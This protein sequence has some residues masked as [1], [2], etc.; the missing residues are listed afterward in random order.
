MK[1][2]NPLVGAMGGP[3]VAA[4]GGG[5]KDTWAVS[6][7]ESPDLLYLL[8]R[9][10]FKVLECEASITRLLEKKLEYGKQMTIRIE[11]HTYSKGDFL[12][13]LCTATQAIQSTQALLGHI[14]EVEYLPV[15][16]MSTAD[17]MMGEMLDLLRQLAAAG[18]SGGGGATL[19]IV[20][21]P[22]DKYGLSGLPYGRCHAAVAYGELVVTLLSAS[23]AAGAAAA[24]Q[25]QQQA[26][27]VER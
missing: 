8:L 4:S 3:G 21:P 19:E 6:F 2:G 18:G 1:Q 14:L 17:G 7:R 20:K 26:V 13:R 11:G 9:P 10:D 15:S 24:A 12:L 16:S 22:Y 23:S 25:Q 5:L 27:K